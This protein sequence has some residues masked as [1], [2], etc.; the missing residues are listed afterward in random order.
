MPIKPR[1]RIRYLL[2]LCEM[3][4]SRA[5]GEASWQRSRC[6]LLAPCTISSWLCRLQRLKVHPSWSACKCFKSLILER[7]RCPF[8]L[9]CASFCVRGNACI[10]GVLSCVQLQCGMSTV[11]SF[12]S[13]NGWIYS[14]LGNL[15]STLEANTVQAARCSTRCFAKI[16]CVFG[17]GVEAA[18]PLIAPIKHWDAHAFRHRRVRHRRKTPAL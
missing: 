15:Q 2:L 8:R 7:R 3:W 16:Y 17:S 11:A 10:G 9:H 4:V 6:D 14:C 1:Y 12:R 5:N 13:S 18:C